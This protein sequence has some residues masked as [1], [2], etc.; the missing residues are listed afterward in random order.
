MSPRRAKFEYDGEAGGTALGVSPNDGSSA[1]ESRLN[2]E[3]LCLRLAADLTAPGQAR[4][5]VADWL[6]SAGCSN[7][8]VQAMS[9]VTSELVTN[10]IVHANSAPEVT[11][12]LSDGLLR[13]EVRDGD[14]APPVVRADDDLRVGGF[15]LRVVD[16]LT[17]GW[18]WEP[19]D[20]GKRVWVETVF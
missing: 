8:V 6:A 18:G 9:V 15:G 16:A 4:R 14:T 19:T 5:G 10:A 11:A 17:D 2:G 1:D 12:I 13:L 20:S 3:V 7:D